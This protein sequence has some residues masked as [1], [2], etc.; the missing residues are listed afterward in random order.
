MADLADLY[1][2]ALKAYPNEKKNH[3]PKLSRDKA[4]LLTLSMALCMNLLVD[5]ASH[6]MQYRAKSSTN[7]EPFTGDTS[8]ANEE[9]ILQ[10]VAKHGLSK[11]WLLSLIESREDHLENKQ[12]TTL[13]DVE[14][15][16]EKSNSVLYYL[17]L[18]ILG[19][20]NIHADHVGSHLGKAEGIV[21]LIRGVP[22]LGSKRIVLLPRDVMM[23]HKVSQEDVIR[24]IRDERMKGAVFDIAC[25][26]KTHIEHVKA[27]MKDVPPAARI[28]LLPEV[29]ISSYLRFLQNSDFDV[30]DSSLQKRNHLLP[31]HLWWAK[32]RKT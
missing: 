31:L 11:R 9:Q 26:A 21:R 1:A 15:Y 12:F 4:H 30:F 28:G 3:P 27:L 24:G 18:Q 7:K 29:T 17:I 13:Q 22:H 25:V 8:M 20:K 14:D 23:Q 6:A 2:G 5:A 19:I 10:A 16:S 32:V